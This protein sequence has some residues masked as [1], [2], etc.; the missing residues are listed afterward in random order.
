MYLHMK[1]VYMETSNFIKNYNEKMH[2]TCRSA[3]EVLTD[4]VED[5]LSPIRSDLEEIIDDVKSG[6]FSNEEIA[7]KLTELCSVI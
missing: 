3:E 4:I 6:K 7:E 5:T 2:R 1:G